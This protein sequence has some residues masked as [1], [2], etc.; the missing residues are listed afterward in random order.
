MDPRLNVLQ[1]RARAWDDILC[2]FDEPDE[3]S[4]EIIPPTHWPETWAL[5]TDPQAGPPVQTDGAGQP[6][7]PSPEVECR[8]LAILANA[9]R[10]AVRSR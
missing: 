8:A 2:W 1:T 6:N 5:R 4:L 7:E 3:I 10:R 9:L